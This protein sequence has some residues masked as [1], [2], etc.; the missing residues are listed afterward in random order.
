MMTDR[1]VSTSAS[2]MFVFDE[3]ELEHDE[4]QEREHGVV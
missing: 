4:R 1:S 3:L 2:V